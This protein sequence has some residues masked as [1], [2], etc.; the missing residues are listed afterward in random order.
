MLNLAASTAP[1]W[2]DRVLP[3]LDEILLDHAH[4]EKK[5]A[6]TAINLI[7][8]YQDEPELVRALSALAR[9]ELE[10]FEQVLALLQARGVPFGRQHPSPY[11][12][13]LRS[14]VREGEPLQYLDTMLCCALIEARSCERMR[15]LAERLEDEE[16]AAFYRALLASEARHHTLY[17]DLAELRF[18]R[19]TVRARL[20]EL[21]AHEAAVIGGAPAEARLHSAGIRLGTSAP[22]RRSDAP[23]R[24]GSSSA[25]G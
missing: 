10:H 2:I 11:A 18:D 4:C 15:I 25:G 3:A 23:A 13:R 24:A 22:L 9:E 6:S 12:R 21:A 17:V 1:D 19:E 5:A 14:A 7:F 16:L 20:V 8:R